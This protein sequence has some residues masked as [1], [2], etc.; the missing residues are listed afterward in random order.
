M[1]NSNFQDQQ[2]E[3]IKI[4]ALSQYTYKNKQVSWKESSTQNNRPQKNNQLKEQTQTECQAKLEAQSQN[5]EN[6]T[7]Q[8]YPSQKINKN[9]FE[10]E[11]KQEIQ[12]QLYQTND[13]HQ[14]QIL[15]QARKNSQLKI[16]P[17]FNV[18]IQ[19]TRI[20]HKKSNSQNPAQRQ[21][22]R[23]QKEKNELQPTQ[24]IQ[25]N[26][27]QSQYS[28]MTNKSEV[29]PT[30][31]S[32]VSGTQNQES[33]EIRLKFSDDP[34]LQAKQQLL[35]EI[36]DILKQIK[37]RSNCKRHSI[38]EDALQLCLMYIPQ[39]RVNRHSFISEQ[40]YQQAK[41]IYQLER[42]RQA[43]AR[44]FYHLLLFSNSWTLQNITNIHKI[45]M[46]YQQT[47]LES[48]HLFYDI[49][50]KTL[51]FPTSIVFRQMPEKPKVIQQIIQNEQNKRIVLSLT[52]KTLFQYVNLPAKEIDED[53]EEFGDELQFID[54]ILNLIPLAL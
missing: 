44:R 21:Q 20:Y 36:H 40:F 1:D 29:S 46:K 14:H 26:T 22:N 43:F 9:S 28:E 37:I 23:I 6:D 34:D 12:S 3:I 7:E 42:N 15:S 2:Q 50:T 11:L 25:S 32:E 8:F 54:M 19:I 49:K 30:I 27:I 24:Q 16:Q 39:I 53:I 5:Q 13:Q 4:D 47:Q 51:Q 52:T 10:N 35:L 17:A 45:I 31:N 18:N 41:E 48:Y 38:L 33:F